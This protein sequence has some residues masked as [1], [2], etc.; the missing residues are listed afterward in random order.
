[1]VKI[2]KHNDVSGI[3]EKAMGHIPASGKGQLG[4]AKICSY[5]DHPNKLSRF[6]CETCGATLPLEA[7]VMCVSAQPRS[8]PKERPIDVGGFQKRPKIRPVSKGGW[9]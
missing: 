5:C 3:G 4:I 2:Y 6:T 7:Y 8:E 9:K 1:M